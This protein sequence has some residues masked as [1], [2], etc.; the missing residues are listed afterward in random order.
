[1]GWMFINF[2]ALVSYYRIYRLLTEKELLNNYSS[3]DVLIHLSRIYKLIGDNWVLSE[4][5]K[6]TRVIIEKLNIP[7]T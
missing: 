7:I 5:P 2:I 1:M 4:I 6:K 3:G